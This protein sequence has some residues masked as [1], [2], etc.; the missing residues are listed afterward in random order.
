MNTIMMIIAFLAGLILVYLFKMM[1]L[2]LVLMEQNI[3]FARFVFIYLETTCINLIIPFKLGEIYRI[4]RLSIET[5]RAQVGVLSVATD[6]FFD[7]AALLILLFGFRYMGQGQFT[8]LMGVMLLVIAALAFLYISFNGAYKYLNR[9]II[10]HKSSAKSMAALHCLEVMN[11]WHSY[12]KQ[13][14]DGRCAL[15]IIF[16]IL[17]WIFEGF[18]LLALSKII[19]EP[20]GLAE[21]SVYISSIFTGNGSVLFK[22]Y[23]YIGMF[24]LGAI[25]FVW[26]I[27]GAI[28]EKCRTRI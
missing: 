27:V 9:Y 26:S 17:G 1:R 12:L 13:L 16:S 23:N 5:K 8:A 21:Y 19:N 3:S 11:D 18:A 6:R 15:M 28:Y 24:L 20:Y 4:C 2:Y 22:C 7:I 14:I 10:V 25:V